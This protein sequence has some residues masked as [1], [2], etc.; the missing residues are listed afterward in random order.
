L[1]L[2]DGTSL[3]CIPYV[4]QFLSCYRSLRFLAYMISFAVPRGPFHGALVYTVDGLMAVCLACIFL[5]F[6]FD[7]IAVLSAMVIALF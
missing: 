2:V 5:F 7:P 6:P 4:V 3:F 1:I